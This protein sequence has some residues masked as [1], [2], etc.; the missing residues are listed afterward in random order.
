MS[1]F[2][3]EIDQLLAQT[4]RSLIEVYLEIQKKAEEQYGPQTV[5]LVEVGSF[6][7][8]Y[9]IDNESECIGKPKEIAQLLNLQLTRLNK[10]VTENSVSNPLLAGFPSLAFDRYMNR[11]VQEQKYTILLIRQ[12][13]APPK[14]ERYIDYVVSPGVNFEYALN[15]DNNFLVSVTLDYNASMYSAGYV[16]IDITTGKTVVS[17]LYSTTDDPNYALDELFRL[18]QTQPT[19][20]Y[21]ITVL[22]EAIDMPMVK[23]YLELSTADTVHY[24]AH[25]PSVAYQNTLFGKVYAIESILSPIEEL[26]MER[27][28]LLSE[29]LAIAL[30]FAIEHDEKSVYQLSRPE[31]AQ[32]HEY[33]YLG[34]NP[35]EQLQIISDRSGDA[36]VLE[37]ID[38]TSTS[39]GRRLLRNRVLNPITSVHA[40]NARY[41]L[42][43]QVASLAKNIRRELQSVY[44]LERIAR[45]I[46]L[47]RLHPFEMN[48][49]YDSLNAANH[50]IDVIKDAKQ[51][52]ALTPYIEE[53]DGLTQ[54]LSYIEKTFSLSA[55]SKVARNQIQSTL[56]HQGF[57]RALD[58]LVQ[59][60]AA[61]EEKL[62][63]IR[64][65]IQ[66]KIATATQNTENVYV[67]IKQLDKEG[68]YISIT[69][70]RYALIAEE[71]QKSFISIDGTVH[72]F[73]DFTIKVQTT[74]VKLT[75]D[76]IDSISQEIT[77]LQKKIAA[78]TAE[79]FLQQLEYINT[80]FGGVIQRSIFTLAQID[81]AVS[82]HTA[83]VERRFVR[84]QIVEV[85]PDQHI[86]E[87][88]Q[89]RHPLV[90]A[91]EENGIYVP[92]DVTLGNRALLNTVDA[93]SPIVQDNSEDVEGVLL[94][95]INSSGKSSLMK[96]IGIA[97]VLAQA[98][99]YVPAEAMRFSIVKELFTRIV[100]RDDFE[101]GLSTF[102]VEMTELKNIFNRCS[103][104]SIILGDEISHGTETLSA[105]S[106]V[107]A[108]I[109]RF[110]EKHSLFVLATHLHQLDSVQQIAECTAI[111]RV[112]LAVRYDEESDAIIFERVLQP[113]TGSSLYGLEFAQSLHMDE[114]FVK[115]AWAIRK[116]LANDYS[117]FELVTKQLSTKYHKDVLLTTCAICKQTV[118]DVHHITPQELADING[119]I[120]HFHKDHKYNLI[121]LCKDCHKKVH[122]GKITIQGFVMTTNG[123]QLQ[124]EEK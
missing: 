109:L 99:L 44:D 42:V 116:T 23:Q 35:L 62:L 105:L 22:N 11:L 40:L 87:I 12:K 48:F 95:G 1:L 49:L 14:V 21:I 5:V 91:R 103:A 72:A 39:I 52:P 13:G 85:D 100:A 98:G 65:A 29:A 18:F 90:E 80:E 7:E 122:A 107:S 33:L 47:G 43:E 19:A 115:K 70:N 67:H 117:E 77:A 37:L 36:S 46:K 32:P 17:E 97:I 66:E 20:E 93:D 75:A 31:I 53:Q 24:G 26:H 16:A 86:L 112:H 84:P 83:T 25:R 82:T 54:A 88:T 4:K 96:S 69:K 73:S 9:G 74:N 120:N 8:V 3:T 108:A 2:R 61:L 57:N 15:H 76:I 78:R 6:F 50:I 71:L 59:Q 58:T 51:C 38:Y 94:Y 101:R 79:L 124:Y 30:E 64:D 45:R 102:G 111:R 27:Q 41:D 55:T 104:Q 63:L 10:S 121:A 81:V 56:F 123:L 113:G 110:Q 34:N 89:L 60:Q 114:E 106:I 68:H 28:P 118:E 119:N 92:N